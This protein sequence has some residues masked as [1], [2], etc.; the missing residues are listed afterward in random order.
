MCVYIYI[1]IRVHV[2]V[3]VCVC[4]S[5]SLYIYIYIRVHVCVCIH[6]YIYIYIYNLLQ[7]LSSFYLE[8]G[9][10]PGLAVGDNYYNNSYTTSITTNSY[11]TII[12]AII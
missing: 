5:L 7:A 2:Y 12:I 1:Y 10:P 6:I 9:R 8:V 11:N 4:I 3:Y